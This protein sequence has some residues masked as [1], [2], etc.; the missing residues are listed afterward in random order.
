MQSAVIVI[1]PNDSRVF[2]FLIQYY[3]FECRVKL[4]DIKLVSFFFQLR[5]FL[6]SPFWRKEMK[7]YYTKK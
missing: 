3:S 6:L 5:Y 7:N 2:I 4:G 1:T